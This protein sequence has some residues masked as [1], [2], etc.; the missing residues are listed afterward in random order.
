MDLLILASLQGREALHS[1]WVWQE[2]HT[3][4]DTE[5]PTWLQSSLQV[6]VSQPPAPA[7][8]LEAPRVSEDEPAKEMCPR[9]GAVA[10]QD[11]TGRDR[12]TFSELCS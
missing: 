4:G 8:G 10:A 6:L 11:C 9:S 5:R 7:P 1:P 2:K 12:A 3:H